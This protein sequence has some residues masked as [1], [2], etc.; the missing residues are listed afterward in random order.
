MNLR[1]W[2]EFEKERGHDSRDM[3]AMGGSG[4]AIYRGDRLNFATEL[5]ELGFNGLTVEEGDGSSGSRGPNRERGITGFTKSQVDH[6]F[7]LFKERH[8]QEQSDKL[9]GKCFHTTP[10]QWV[11]DSGASHHMTSNFAALTNVYTLSIPIIISQSDGRQVK[12]EQAGMVQLGPAI[13]PK[14]VLY[15]PTFKCN[16]ISAQKLAQDESCVVS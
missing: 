12:V 9:S 15:T 4:G 11:L 5:S 7:T 6:L 16:L 2:S 14:D 8:H 13:W 10:M 3:T 1:S